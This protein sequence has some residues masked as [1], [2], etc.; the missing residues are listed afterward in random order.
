MTVRVARS[1]AA[2]HREVRRRAAPGSEA[3]V[4]GAVLA[5]DPQV[6][7][8][9]AAGRA[10]VDAGLAALDLEVEERAVPLA[11]HVIGEPRVRRLHLHDAAGEP[12]DAALEPVAARA[13]RRT[14]PPPLDA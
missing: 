12:V 4:V 9:A 11:P 3:G 8:E 14:D 1:R 2:H 6:E 7:P 10:Q 13:G 5:V